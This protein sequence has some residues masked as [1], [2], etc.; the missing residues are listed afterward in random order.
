[1]KWLKIQKNPKTLTVKL[2]VINAF[3]K[4]EGHRGQ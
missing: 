1:M 2:E 4:A 3:S